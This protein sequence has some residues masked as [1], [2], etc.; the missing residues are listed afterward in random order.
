MAAIPPGDARI[1][2]AVAAGGRPYNFSG[3][4]GELDAMFLSV[5]L[6]NVHKR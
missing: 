2:T 3:P 1:R 4:L 5:S 6:A